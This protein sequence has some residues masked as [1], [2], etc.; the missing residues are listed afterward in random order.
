MKPLLD[1]IM[2]IFIISL[3]LSFSSLS[4]SA[5][6]LYNQF[7]SSDLY[8]SSA[9]IKLIGIGDT[10]NLDDLL[11][12]DPD[13]NLHRVKN[14]TWLYLWLLK[15]SIESWEY[16]E[17]FYFHRHYFGMDKLIFNNRR[18]I[19]KYSEI[20]MDAE[21][22]YIKTFRYY[23]FGYIINPQFDMEISLLSIT[24]NMMGKNANGKDKYLYVILS[25]KLKF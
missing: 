12:E 16:E 25:F 20:L 13:S 6:D 8:K 14:Y 24:D 9:D 19:S 3:I 1:I 2:K 4:I 15:Y 23:S 22:D 21:G 11:K 17:D 7:Y 18:Y 5:Q 10:W